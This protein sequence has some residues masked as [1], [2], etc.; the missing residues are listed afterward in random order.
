M[1]LTEKERKLEKQFAEDYLSLSLGL[2][3]T[4]LL[5]LS[6]KAELWWI[7]A[8]LG[9]LFAIL[10]VYLYLAVFCKSARNKFIEQITTARIQHINLFV[11]F[12]A[13]GLGLVK[14]GEMVLSTLGVACVALGYAILIVG[15]WKGAKGRRKEQEAKQTRSYDVMKKYLT[16]VKKTL[17]EIIA[18]LKEYP[19][20]RDK[21]LISMLSGITNELAS[22]DAALEKTDEDT[23]ARLAEVISKMKA[24]EFLASYSKDIREE[25]IPATKSDQ[26]K[27][28]VRRSSSIISL[29]K[30]MRHLFDK[31][32]LLSS[33]TPISGV[34]ADISK[35]L[36]M[37]EG[38]IGSRV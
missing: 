24:R 19:E 36:G 7:L 35:L 13:V 17:N 38:V 18:K 26:K 20:P 5:L 4:A 34:F 6:F 30:S 31:L 14:F 9:I 29:F 10:S 1:E 16:S 11:G 25:K 8:I 12:S 23:C 37:L 22:A 33:G 32:A 27:L 3:A 21:L 15:T 2:F 28:Q